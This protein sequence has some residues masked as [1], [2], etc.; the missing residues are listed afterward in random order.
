M[1]KEQLT[2]VMRIFVPSMVAWFSARG[3]VAADMV[4][5]MTDMLINVLVGIILLGAMVWSF[6]ANSKT[7]RI[8]SVAE[9]EEGRT[10]L[11]SSVADMPE[12]KRVVAKP[13]IAE[14]TLRDHE[15]VTER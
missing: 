6:V 1:D 10:K 4:G 5:P 3:L 7:A 11:I 2:G 15:K 13:E 14:G 12:V 8:A 9:T